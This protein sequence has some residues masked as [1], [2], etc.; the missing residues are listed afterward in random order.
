MQTQINQGQTAINS[1]C[2]APTLPEVM[3]RLSAEKALVSA[4]LGCMPASEW[5]SKRCKELG[6]R[7]QELF[8]TLDV[9]KRMTPMPHAIQEPKQ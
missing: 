6:N 7:E 3:R 9:L 2:Q 1:E 4:E 8:T 5:S